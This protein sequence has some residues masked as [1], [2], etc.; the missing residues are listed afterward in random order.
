MVHL[1][2][3]YMK[4]P[5]NLQQLGLNAEDIITDLQDADRVEI[6]MANG[7]LELSNVDISK[8][9]TDLMTAQRSYQFNARSITIADQMLGLINGIR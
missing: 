9:M 3:T 6:A 4:M 5:D 8:E 2:E 1:S 7:M